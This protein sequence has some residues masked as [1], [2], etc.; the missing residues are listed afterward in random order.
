MV[1]YIFGILES[2]NTDLAVSHQIIYSKL[3]KIIIH[4]LAKWTT[5][6]IWMKT[7]ELIPKLSLKINE[8]IWP[9]PVMT[10]DP[11]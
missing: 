9:D 11:V 1:L 4:K 8:K 3:G 10:S 6:F 7:L 5:M 2:S